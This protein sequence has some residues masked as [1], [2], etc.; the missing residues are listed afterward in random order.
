MSLH[1]RDSV[2]TKHCLQAYVTTLLSLHELYTSATT[3]VQGKWMYTGF[4]A[5]VERFRE[6]LTICLQLQREFCISVRLYST[7]YS[8]ENVLQHGYFLWRQIRTSQIQKMTHY[9]HDNKGFTNAAVSFYSHM[10]YNLGVLAARLQVK[11]YLAF[12]GR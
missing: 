6:Q 11:Q 5:Q 1:N 9:G 3:S 7:G 4:E 10:L 2:S 8:F 12:R